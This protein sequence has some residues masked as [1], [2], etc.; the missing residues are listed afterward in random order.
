LGFGKDDPQRLVDTHQVGEPR[1]TIARDTARTLSLPP[2]I[3]ANRHVEQSR[4]LLVGEFPFAEE[5]QHGAKHRRRF[6]LSYR[7]GPKGMGDGIN[8]LQCQHDYSPYGSI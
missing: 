3:G 8:G 7:V 4:C 2:P 5:I 6:L 1:R